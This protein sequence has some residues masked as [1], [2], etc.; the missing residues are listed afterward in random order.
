[1]KSFSTLCISIFTL[2]VLITSCKKEKKEVIEKP[3]PVLWENNEETEELALQKEHENPRMQFKLLQ[4]KFTDKNDIYADLYWEV[5]N[6]SEE[7]YKELSPFIL[8]KNIPSIQKEIEKGTFTY[9]ELTLFYL[10]RI[11]KYELN[12]ETTLHTIIALNPRVLD[13]AVERD[14]NNES[15]VHPIYGM[16]ILLKDNI[17]TSNMPTT[18]GAVVLQ[19]NNPTENAFI[20]S[21]LESKGA[22]ILGKVNLSEWAYYF[23][24]GCPLGY[25][26]IGGQTLNPYGRKIFETGG[27]SAGSGTAVAA[28]YAV[29]AIGTE[30]SGSIISPT[31]QNSLVGLKPTIGVV[32]R[33]GIVPISHSLDTAGPMAKNTIDSAI[34]LDAI[35]GKDEIDTATI[36]KDHDYV[37]S[38]KNS[39]LKG[40]RLGALNNLLEDSLYAETIKILENQ[41]AEIIKYDPPQLQLNGFLTLLNIEMREDLPKYL[42][43]YTSENISVKNLSEVMA[44]N[45]KD[46]LLNMPY[47]Q[48]LFDGIMVDSTSSE[49]FVK[50]RDELMQKGNQFFQEPME[51]HQLDA[52]ISINNYH[53]GYAAVGRRP[54]LALPMGYK[55]NDEPIAITFI[56]ASNSEALLLQLGA[57]YEKANPVRK[58]PEQFS[59]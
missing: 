33:T 26:A 30:T 41:G 36:S 13:E 24:S 34:V 2:S 9:K 25:S 5:T 40:K 15:K 50:L 39:T 59:K 3:V 8:E 29:A 17:N 18:A 57:A 23:C 12:P 31:S 55:E 6:F 19:E 54:C 44:F 4:S 28:N 38:I 27:S 45:Q 11:Y 47:N 7:R 16:P 46:S 43:N 42:A 1:M 53:S 22:L 20:V 21:Q 32:S 56:G 58:I 37:S 35:S 10:K 51:K 49:D 48:A 52:V 14:N